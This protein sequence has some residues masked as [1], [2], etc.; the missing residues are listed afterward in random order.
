VNDTQIDQCHRIE[1][2]SLAIGIAQLHV[3][4]IELPASGGQ[5]WPD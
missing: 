4:L 3:G 5:I 2:E 1:K